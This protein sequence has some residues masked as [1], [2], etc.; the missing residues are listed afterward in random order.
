MVSD[1]EDSLLT[2]L[3]NSHNRIIESY[4]RSL[5]NLLERLHHSQFIY[6]LV[7]PRNFVPIGV[8]IF[9][10][11]LVAI[12]MTFAGLSIWFREEK[13]STRLRAEWLTLHESTAGQTQQDDAVLEV[14]PVAQ[15]RMWLTQNVLDSTNVKVEAAGSFDSIQAGLEACSRPFQAALFST[16]A[17]FGAGLGLLWHASV[18]FSTESFREQEHLLLAVLALAALAPFGVAIALKSCSAAPA[19]R[20]SNLIQAFTL[21]Q[22]GMTVAVMSTL[23][24]AFATAL[25][26]SSLAVINVGKLGLSRDTKRQG[27][28]SLLSVV[29]VFLRYTMLLAISPVALIAIA[30]NPS[31]QVGGLRQVLLSAIYDWKVVGTKAIPLVYL[32]IY[33]IIFQTQVSLSSYLM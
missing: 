18:T 16:L 28:I 21:L 27:R 32:L 24:F 30:Q 29:S 4:V 25:G 12:S 23:N 3:V 26:F 31:P 8:V 10:P 7:S 1:G 20:I 13:V 17:A 22:A 11:L 14:V 2:L 15:Q 19:Y 33:P 6:L 5:S 9:I